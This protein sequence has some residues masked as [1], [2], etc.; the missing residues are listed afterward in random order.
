MGLL[1][2]DDIFTVFGIVGDGVVH[3]G[4]AA[5]IHQVYDQLELMQTL[6]L[7]HFGGI[8]GFNQ[9][10]ETGFDQFHS[11]TAEY[12]LLTE[13][14]GFGLVLEGYLDDAGTTA[15]DGAGIREGYFAG[16]TRCC[17]TPHARL[18]QS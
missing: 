9:G 12:S 15:T 18:L 1:G 3:I 8:S 16:L 4:N 2:S 7:G 5:L 10:L 14:I 13:Q 11:T 17:P 6:K